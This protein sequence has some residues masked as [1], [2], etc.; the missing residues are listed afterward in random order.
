MIGDLSR[1]GLIRRLR[2]EGVVIDSGAVSSRVFSPAPEVADAVLAAYAPYPL[3][4]GEHVADYR[5]KISQSTGLRRFFRRQ[6]L[7]EVGISVPITPFPVDITPMM[8]EMTLNW[9]AATRTNRYLIFHSAVVEKNG[10]A[11]ILPGD[12]GQGKSTLCAAL[13]TSGWRLF[14]DEFGFMDL[15][16]GMMVPNVRPISL[17][18][19]SIDVMEARL[20]VNALTRRLHDTPK[21][22]IAYLPAPAEAVARRHEPASPAAVVFPFYHPEIEDAVV[23]YPKARGLIALCGG[24]ANFEML[25]R[26]AFDAMCSFTDTHPIARIAYSNLDNAVALIERIVEEGVPASEEIPA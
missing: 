8:I 26:E 5:I 4:D 19:E 13:A 9:C 18:N 12:S 22:T 3:I 10:K 7:G 20:G 14:S 24:A 6:V 23:A 15:A 25:G 21:G 1:A 11:V 16:T 17:K 2:S